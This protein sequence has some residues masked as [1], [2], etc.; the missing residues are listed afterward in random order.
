[1]NKEKPAGQAEHKYLLSVTKISFLIWA[2]CVIGVVSIF[3]YVLLIRKE[4]F[5]KAPEVFAFSL[6]GLVVLGSLAFLVGI[7]ALASLLISKSKQKQNSLL[8]LIKLSFVLAIFPIYLLA[9]V[10]KPLQLVKKA[11]QSGMKGLLKSLHPKRV[12]GRLA[13]SA[14]IVLV[15][16]PIWIGGYAVAAVTVQQSLGYG[17]EFITISGTGSMFPTFPKGDGKDPKEL[18][19]QIVGTPGMMRYPNGLVIAGRRYFGYKIGR[20][21]IVVIEND[22]IREMTK[23]MYGDPSGWVKRVVGM[24]GDTIELRE[25]IVYLNGEPFKEP[26]TAQPRSTFGETF[27]SECTKVTVPENSI[28]V[29]GDNRKGSGDS[30]EIGFIEISAINHVLPLKNQTGTLDKAWRD[31]ANDFDEKSKIKLDKDKYLQL[32]N[33]KRKEAGAKELKYQ[34]KLETSANKRGEVILKF[35]DFSF[36]ATESGYTMSKSMRDAGYSNTAWGE[37]PTHGYYE[38]EELIDNQFQFPESK[39]FLTDKT[40]QEVGISEVEGEING[41]PTQVIVQHFA[42]YVPPNYKQADIDSWKTS[43][44]RLREI[45]PGWN[46]LKDNSNF[47][48]DNKTDVDRMSE[49]IAVRIGN[50]ST[51]VSRM[52]A[53]QWLTGAEQKMVDQDKTLYNEQEALA[54]KLNGR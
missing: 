18:A 41:C 4:L 34:P 44:T 21:D 5:D 22:K 45:Q 38:A 48:Q 27:L 54:T 33:E 28:F 9:H 19:K 36:E 16:F 23:N 1:M 25:G 29:M 50:I 51:I 8:F 30:R 14:A 7:V 20:G 37:A 46:S 10:L 2:A 15:M 17:T 49:I 47:Y 39:K 53:N 43:L 12:L 52:E 32:L 40:Y 35:D 31:T 6:L 13:L 11:K 24:P 26:Y 3:G 42:G